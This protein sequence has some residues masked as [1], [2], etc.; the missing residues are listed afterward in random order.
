MFDVC[1]G[2]WSRVFLNSRQSLPKYAAVAY[3]Q[4]DNILYVSW[5]SPFHLLAILL[6]GTQT[7]E[8]KQRHKDTATNIHLDCWGLNV[9]V[10][11]LKPVAVQ[12]TVFCLWILERITWQ[13]RFGGTWCLH[14]RGWR[15]YVQVEAELFR[16]RR[17][18]GVSLT[19]YESVRCP[20][21]GDCHMEGCKKWRIK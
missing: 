2:I 17:F 6:A 10:Q 15:T 5:R 3:L 12:M 7:L 18:E 9:C 11:D 21:A 13:R 8:L 16:Y 1:L 19:I 14:F 4:T 20:K